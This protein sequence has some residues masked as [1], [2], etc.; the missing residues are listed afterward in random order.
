[1]KEFFSIISNGDLPSFYINTSVGVELT[2][3]PSNLLDF[4]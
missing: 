4:F 1:M 2:F 3:I